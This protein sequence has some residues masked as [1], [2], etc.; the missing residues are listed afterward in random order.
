MLAVSEG[1]QIALIGAICTGLIAP[2]WLAW[3]NSRVAK[4]QLQPNGGT[5]IADKIA[6][7]EQRQSIDHGRLRNMEA[8]QKIA[9]DKMD[10]MEE[11]VDNHIDFMNEAHNR[12]NKKE[13]VTDDPE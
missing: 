5:S 1:T 10:I 8:R 3:W 7:I 2:T 9:S 11:K 4:K 6:R 12:T 13:R